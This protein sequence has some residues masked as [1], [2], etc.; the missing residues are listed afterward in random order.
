MFETIIKTNVYNTYQMECSKNAM[1]II[2]IKPLHLNFC[3]SSSE[4]KILK[5]KSFGKANLT[6]NIVNCIQQ[7]K[8]QFDKVK[9]INSV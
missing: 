1:K 9:A 2:Q 6:S 5:I 8:F 4:E 3:L 7:T